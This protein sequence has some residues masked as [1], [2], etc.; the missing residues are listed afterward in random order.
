[1][2]TSRMQHRKIIV[3]ILNSFVT[4]NYGFAWSDAVQGYVVYT[5]SAETGSSFYVAPA[6][7]A[8]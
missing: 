4:N 6:I 1:M 8:L 2:F 5:E 3:I 7:S